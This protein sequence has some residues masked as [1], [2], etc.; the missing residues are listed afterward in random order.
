MQERSAVRPRPVVVVDNIMLGGV[1]EDADVDIQAITRAD[2]VPAK[3]FRSRSMNTHAADLGIYSGSCQG[4]VQEAVADG[5]EC[6]AVVYKR[7]NRLEST[8]QS[9][10]GGQRSNVIYRKEEKTLKREVVDG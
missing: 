2:F 9:S 10:D 8:Q 1:V 7:D 3:V 4:L 5:V 6:S